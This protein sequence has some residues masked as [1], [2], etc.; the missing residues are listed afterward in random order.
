MKDVWVQDIIITRAM[1]PHASTLYLYDDSRILLSN[2]EKSNMSAADNLSALQTSFRVWHTTHYKYIDDGFITNKIFSKIQ[3]FI[4]L[5]LCIRRDY[6][7][8]WET[9]LKRHY[10]WGRTSAS[11]MGHRAPPSRVDVCCL[12]RIGQISQSREWALRNEL[13]TCL[14]LLNVAV[15]RSFLV[16]FQCSQ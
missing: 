11:I 14:A 9:L 2:E 4:S 8:H 7:R 10:P 3:F 15:V 16:M 12:Q 6:S 5:T 1:A 13:P